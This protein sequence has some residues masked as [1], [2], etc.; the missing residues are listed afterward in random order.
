MNNPDHN[1]MK[2]ARFE[3]ISRW[4]SDT[5]GL[6]YLSL[7]PASSDAS[8]R[9]YF[10][11]ECEDQSFIVMD[12]PPDKESC[13]SFLDIS[14]RLLASGLSVPIIHADD[15]AN[16]LLLLSDLGVTSYLDKLNND[17]VDDLYA[18][19]I[20]ALLMMQQNTSV[21][22][23]PEYDRALL[24]NEMQLFDDWL[25]KKHLGL[26]LDSSQQKALQSCFESLAE[27]ALNQQ[28]VFVHRDYHSRNLM[29]LDENNPGIIDYQDAVYGPISY[30]LV[31][32]IKDCYIQWPE[33]KIIR[34]VRA[35]YEQSPALT[36]TSLQQFRLDL[37][38][39]GAQRHLK[40]S[41]IFARLCHR[42]GK[43]GY[44]ADIERTLNYITAAGSGCSETAFLQ[45]LLNEHVLPLLPEA[46]A[47][48]M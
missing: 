13:N 21:E 34:W 14:R 4:L 38:L 17:T 22:Q 7:E 42:D 6:D 41:G 33:E 10:R 44:L 27:S 1:D 15:K 47:K 2:D 35:F 25:L 48:C 8:F 24:M 20:S 26:S 32:L 37:D 18:D 5:L 45:D 19:A 23:L 36:E 11:V 40:A 16:G 30:D 29:V 46:N 39:M 28:Q 9:R 43:K 12:A 31:S 3:L